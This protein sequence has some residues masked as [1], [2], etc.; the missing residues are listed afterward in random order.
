MKIAITLFISLFL[1][2]EASAQ[3]V[4]NWVFMNGP[5]GGYEGNATSS[6]EY[7][8]LYG[9][10]I[11]YRSEDGE[12]W[13]QI[14]EETSDLFAMEANRLVTSVFDYRRAETVIKISTDHGDSWKVISE[15]SIAR[16]FIDWVIMDGVIYGLEKWD[17][18]IFYTQDEG[19]TW[20]S[21]ATPFQNLFGEGYKLRNL[22]GELFLE[23]YRSIYK[24]DINSNTSWE[25]INPGVHNLQSVVSDDDYLIFASDKSLHL[26]N[27]RGL[28]WTVRSKQDA[29]SGGELFRFHDR[30]YHCYPTLYYTS[31]L[32]ENW[33]EQLNIPTYNYDCSCTT[34]KDKIYMTLDDTGLMRIDKEGPPENLN[35]IIT[36][37][38]ISE[39]IIDGSRIWTQEKQ[40]SYY[41]LEKNIWECIGDIP[42]EGP[43]NGYSDRLII[44]NDWVAKVHFYGEDFLL[45]KD[46]GKT[47]DL[48]TFQNDDYLDFFDILHGN[49]YASFEDDPIV[50]KSAN[51]GLTWSQ[52][53]LE[54]DDNGYRTNLFIPFNGADYLFVD[55]TQFKSMDQ[56][57]TWEKEKL[58]FKFRTVNTVGE[59]LVADFNSS[60]L[61]RWTADGINWQSIDGDFLNASSSSVYKTEEGYAMLGGYLN[62][63]RRVVYRVNELWGHWSREF[64]YIKLNRVFTYKARTFGH[65]YTYDDYSNGLY[66]MNPDSTPVV[67]S[68]DSEQLAISLNIYPQPALL[69]MTLE[70]KDRTTL[71]RI[72]LYDMIGKVVLSSESEQVKFIHDG[73]YDIDVSKLNAGV[74]V[75][76]MQDGNDSITRKIVVSSR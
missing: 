2:C 54:Y 42:R 75:V 13:E 18:K 31:D 61:P 26:T 16:D 45:S 72:C 6:D 17:G 71:D 68:I 60:D 22:G 57:F 15:D 3:S 28:T 73:R 46:K 20:S 25:S 50:W 41:D 34:F 37:S 63:G 30:Y 32:G 1:I 9:D 5:C 76:V 55:E 47:W 53:E 10:D 51:S 8:Y 29:I 35:E 24:A 36:K 48:K 67:S 58:G 52:T 59:Y 12:N 27:D 44:E 43:Y 11:M 7:I 14:F 33:S 40:L 39:V 62:D 69:Q 49:L 64:E 66:E 19:E 70:L 65:N 74:Y 4:E 38:Q 21:F 56:G 23:A